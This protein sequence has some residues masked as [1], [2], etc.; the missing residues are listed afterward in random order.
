MT[1]YDLELFMGDLKEA[2]QASQGEEPVTINIEGDGLEFD[3]EILT[4][5]RITRKA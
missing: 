5:Y 1:P 3:Y 4:T 2:V